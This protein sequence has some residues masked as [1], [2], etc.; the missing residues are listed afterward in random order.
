MSGG[1]SSCSVALSGFLRSFIAAGTK[2]SMRNTPT[3]LS[4]F[5]ESPVCGRISC[6][7]DAT[8]ATCCERKRIP[9]GS[10]GGSPT[11][12]SVWP[13]WSGCVTCHMPGPANSPVTMISSSGSSDVWAWEISRLSP[14]ASTSRIVRVFFMRSVGACALKKVPGLNAPDVGRRFGAN[15]VTQHAP[16]KNGSIQPSV[17]SALE[18]T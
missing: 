8:C 16:M 15:L 18:E 3:F 13:G 17:V 9:M 10:S 2:V 12:Q 1:I 5:S 6:D 7:C 4:G 11:I 14:Q